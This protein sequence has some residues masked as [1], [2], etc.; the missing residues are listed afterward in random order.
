V[1][2]YVFTAT[3]SNASEGVTTVT[4]DLGDITI[5]DGATTGTL[6]IARSE[7]HASEH[8]ATSLSACRTRTSSSNFE[9]LTVGTASATAHVNDTITDATLNLFP[10]TTLFR[11]V[12]NYV[13][14]ATLSN[15]SEGVT[16]VTTDLGDI[17]IADGATTGTLVIA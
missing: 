13:F 4:T 8:D 16:T 1:A 17:T 6:V 3:L 10:Y 7:E 9:N 11:S 12:A 2:N 15:A 14:T 5:A